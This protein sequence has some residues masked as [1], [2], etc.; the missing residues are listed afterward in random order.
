M[1]ATSSAAV[2]RNGPRLECRQS[3][4][5]AAWARVWHGYTG[6]PSTGRP[7]RRCCGRGTLGACVSACA[8]GRP[9]GDRVARRVLVRRSEPHR[10]VVAAARHVEGR[11]VRVVVNEVDEWDQSLHLRASLSHLHR[12]RLPVRLRPIPLSLH[13]LASQPFPLTPIALTSKATADPT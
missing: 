5:R 13:L 3:V 2:A 6:A 10:P 1:P 8:R 9:E 7:H 11:P 4:V 12:S